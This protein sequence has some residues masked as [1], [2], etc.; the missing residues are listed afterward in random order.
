MNM[1]LLKEEIRKAM[2]PHY[3]FVEPP[4]YG[5]VLAVTGSS[6]T[7]ELTVNKIPVSDIPV[8]SGVSLSVGDA[9]LVNFVGGMF[10]SPVIV[11]KF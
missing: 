10:G 2:S 6:A 9:V 11:G 3:N 7:V 8:L 4:Q 1:A 5:K